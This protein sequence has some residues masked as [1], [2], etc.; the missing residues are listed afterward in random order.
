MIASLCWS[1]FFSTGCWFEIILRDKPKP[2]HLAIFLNKI[3]FLVHSA[4]FT[5]RR[6]NDPKVLKFIPDFAMEASSLSSDLFGISST[7]VDWMSDPSEPRYCLCNQVSYGVM[8][9]CDNHAV[10]L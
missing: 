6:L 10:R 7:D 1:T 9:A 5:T 2:F 4:S 3:P 8:V